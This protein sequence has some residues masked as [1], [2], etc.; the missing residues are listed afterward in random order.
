MSMQQSHGPRS[1]GYGLGFE[2]ID[3]GDFKVIGHGGSDWSELAIAY[4]YEPSD[5]TVIAWL[6]REEEKERGKAPRK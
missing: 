4:F 6:A 2:V 1:Q 3:Y 5:D